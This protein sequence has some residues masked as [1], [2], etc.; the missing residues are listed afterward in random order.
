MYSD[1][2]LQSFV[3]S[4]K[5]IKYSIPKPYCGSPNVYLQQQTNPLVIITSIIIIVRR[6]CAGRRREKRPC[7]RIVEPNQLISGLFAYGAHIFHRQCRLEV[8]VLW[9]RGKLAQYRPTCMHN[10]SAQPFLARSL[11]QSTS[12]YAYKHIYRVNSRMHMCDVLR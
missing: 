1:I 7:F 6:I 3:L 8:V 11:K 9:R 10:G 2:F 4:R 5:K 12:T